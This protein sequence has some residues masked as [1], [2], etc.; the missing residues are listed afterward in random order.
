MFFIAIALT[1]KDLPAFKITDRNV[2]S[3]VDYHTLTWQQRAIDLN[4]IKGQPGNVVTGVRLV[5]FGAH[6]NLEV[7][8]TEFDFEAGR[9]VEPQKTSIW[10]SSYHTIDQVRSD[11]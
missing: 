9:L 10:H 5:R 6:L 2:T 11:K 4:E 3:G 7:R 8:M 1:Q